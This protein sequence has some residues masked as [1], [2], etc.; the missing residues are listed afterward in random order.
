MKGPEMNAETRPAGPVA[1]VDE[2]VLRWAELPRL[3]QEIL[4]RTPRAQWHRIRPILALSPETSRIL[5]LAN[6]VEAILPR[7]SLGLRQWGLSADART[8]KAHEL[9]QSIDEFW[10]GVEG[11]EK[12]LEKIARSCGIWGSIES[13]KYPARPVAAPRAPKPPVVKPKAETALSPPPLPKPP[14]EPE[15]LPEAVFEV[16]GSDVDRDADGGA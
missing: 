13:R 9:I 14:T 10:A 15:A 11:I 5:E 3:L 8:R 16:E 7:S 2:K 6:L 4:E 1:R 12:V